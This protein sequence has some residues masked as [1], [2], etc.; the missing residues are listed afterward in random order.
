VAADVL[1]PRAFAELTPPLNRP[2]LP[3]SANACRGRFE[4]ALRTWPGRSL[5]P[6]AA[7]AHTGPRAHPQERCG[8]V[9]CHGLTNRAIARKLLLS[10]KATD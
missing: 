5:N 7:D 9:R 10:C 3:M 8:R 1:T 6:T 4:S 2:L